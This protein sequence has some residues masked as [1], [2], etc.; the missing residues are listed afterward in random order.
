MRASLVRNTE[1]RSLELRSALRSACG[2]K[3]VFVPHM[4]LQIMIDDGFVASHV[5]NA[6]NCMYICF[7]L[8]IQQFV[9]DA[10]HVFIDGTAIHSIYVYTCVNVYCMHVLQ[11][12]AAAHS[13]HNCSS[14]IPCIIV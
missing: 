9:C 14:L 12:L 3:S 1:A 6:V 2:L 4:L 8:W 13:T 10:Y 11:V 7:M 5:A